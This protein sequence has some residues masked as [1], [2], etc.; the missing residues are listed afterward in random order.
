[1]KRSTDLTTRRQF[2]AAGSSCI[3]ASRARGAEPDPNLV[4]AMDAVRAAI[5]A[6][7][8][9]PD[10]PVYHFHPPANWNNDPNGTLFYKGWHHLFYQLNPFGTII[11]DQHWGHARSKDLVNWEH[12]PIA[13]WPSPDKGERA[14][15]SGG[16][17]VANDGLP[18]LIYTSIGHPQ[19]EQWMAVPEDENLISWKKFTGNPVL[20][21]AAHGSVTVNQWRD[22]FLFREAGQ[23][24]LVCGGNANTGRGGAGQVRLYRATRDD[25]SEWKYLGVVFQALERETYNIECPNLFKLDGK[26]V[27]IISPHRS[28]EYFVG[29]LDIDRV[30]FTPET[31]GVLDAGDAYASNIS[32]D[33]QGRTILW[34]WGR[35]NTPQG[36]GWN[37]VMAMPRILSIGSDGFLR[38]RVPDEFEKLRGDLK[39]YPSGPLSASPLLLE[40]GPGDAAEIEAEFSGANNTSFGFEVRR[41]AAGKPAVT[42]AIQRGMLT[43]ANARAYV[44]NAE[45]YKLRLYLDKRCLE[46]YVNDG[47]VALYNL[48]DAPPEDQGLAVFART[49]NS[50]FGNPNAAATVRLESLKAWRM[51]S[52]AFSLDRFRV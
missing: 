23:I 13:I 47:A 12:L 37:G 9:D 36:R 44:G 50:G 18:R 19:P 43:V 7:S 4:K 2:V 21:A 41:S 52:A 17:I 25:L 38:Q 48:V 10:R 22:P 29:S 5:P 14:I 49:A 6:A 32:R 16:A 11:A 26:W 30:K 42:V 51:K 20:T 28:C 45:R 15:F 1:M 24:L 34:L 27:L 39:S 46:V 3:A 8:A 31:H 35:T 40:D 33:D